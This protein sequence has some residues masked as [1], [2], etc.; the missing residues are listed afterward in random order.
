MTQPRTHLC[1]I[2]HDFQSFVRHVLAEDLS[3]DRQP[4]GDEYVHQRANAQTKKYISLR[5]KDAEEKS[6]TESTSPKTTLVGYL[7]TVLKPPSFDMAVLDDRAA[8]HGTI[9][10]ARPI[11]IFADPISAD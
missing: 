7:T 4:R 2:D 3:T 5:G 10:S 9:Y 11:F 1:Q 6:R 8:V